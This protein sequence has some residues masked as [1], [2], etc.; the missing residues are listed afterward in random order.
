MRNSPQ[1]RP[2]VVCTYFT[3]VSRIHRR[4]GSGAENRNKHGGEVTHHTAGSFFP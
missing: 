3:K 4:H 2:G 1:S